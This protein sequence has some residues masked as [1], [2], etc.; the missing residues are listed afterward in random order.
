MK[1]IIKMS[2]LIILLISGFANAQLMEAIDAIQAH[3]ARLDSAVFVQASPGTNLGHNNWLIYDKN[4]NYHEMV[5][6]PAFNWDAT[7]GFSSTSLH[8]AFTVN[9]VRK[10][11]F[12]GKYEASYLGGHAVTQASGLVAQ[13]I[14]FDNANATCDSLNNGT[15]INGFHMVTNAEWAAICL[16]SK[17]IMGSTEVKGNN[18]F[19]RDWS[20]GTIMGMWEPGDSANFVNGTSPARWLAGSGGVTTAHDGAYG[21]RDLNGN[22]WEW[23]KGMRLNNGEINIIPNNDAANP[24]ADVSSSSLLWKA[25]LQDGSLVPPGTA[26]TL[27]VNAAGQISD[28]TSATSN[29]HP[30][31]SFTCDASVSS[32]CAGV[33]LLK[34]LMLYATGSVLDDY[35]WSNT[36]IEAIPIRGGNWGDGA[37]AGLR[38]LHLGD[39]RGGADYGLGFRVAFVW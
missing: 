22:V 1:N 30:F 18:A 19:G 6:I 15:T 24:L 32:S 7:S 2:L 3:L 39:V 27:K 17:N 37:Y 25:I 5:E 36:G 4:G 9:G 21:I 14:N 28:T 31:E 10:R 33:A 29:A 16:V 8:P 11:I 20:V 34:T 35:F 38:A 12:I 23:N 26:H 13:S